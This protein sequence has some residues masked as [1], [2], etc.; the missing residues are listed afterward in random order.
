MPFFIICSYVVVRKSNVLP[1]F[2]E[3]FVNYAY[4]KVQ[5][6]EHLRYRGYAFS[7]LT[8]GFAV[9][10]PHPLYVVIL[11][12]RCSSSLRKK[13]M[14]TREKSN[15]TLN[16]GV[17]NEFLSEIRAKEKDESVVKYCNK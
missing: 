8:N 2:D 14:E 10:V 15:E 1:L 9:D 11:I 12:M 17:Y 6:L 13:F 7:I 16:L 5:W 4:N 3:R